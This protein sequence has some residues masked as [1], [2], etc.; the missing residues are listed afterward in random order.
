MFPQS[1]A[2]RQYAQLFGTAFQF[3]QSIRSNSKLHGP[4]F[5]LDCEIAGAN[6]P[7]RDEW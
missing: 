6:L 7:K 1:D 2:L 3:M 5:V 4:K